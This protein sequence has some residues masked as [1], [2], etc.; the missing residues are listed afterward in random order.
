MKNDTDG[1]HDSIAIQWGDGKT[2]IINVLP[3]EDPSIYHESHR[4]PPDT[5]I[6]SN[7]TCTRGI[8]N[9]AFQDTIEERVWS[10][11]E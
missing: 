7:D 5:A 4:C 6:S 9:V 1:P 8:N 2:H 11:S 3:T 10:S